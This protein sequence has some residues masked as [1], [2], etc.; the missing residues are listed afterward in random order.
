M[1]TI[2]GWLSREVRA[3]SR[4]K[5]WRCQSLCQP[6][7]RVSLMATLRPVERWMALD[8]LY[9]RRRSLAFD[10]WLLLRTVKAVVTMRGAW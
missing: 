1:V 2:S 9:L 8:R 10:L 6:A 4:A 3:T 5:R 7:A